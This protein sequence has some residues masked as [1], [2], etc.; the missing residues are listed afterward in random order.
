MRVS[1]LLL[2]FA[3]PS[4]CFAGDVGV[5]EMNYL[6]FVVAPDGSDLPGNSKALGIIADYGRCVAAGAPHPFLSTL[7]DSIGDKDAQWYMLE[8]SPSSCADRSEGYG[9]ALPL[10]ARGAY[11]E[12][13]LVNDFDLVSGKVR[14]RPQKIFAVPDAAHKASMKDNQK[15]ALSFVEFGTCVAKVDRPDLAKLFGTQVGTN[16]EAAAFTALIPALSQCLTPGMSL[17]V[18]KLKLRGYLA[19]GAY[20]TLAEAAE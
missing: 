15:S 20:R 14:S 18:N 12:Y 16:A 3:V 4:V 6:N 17:R 19:E 13:S 9:A 8:F 5:E 11:A 10:I 7:P 1:L 2:L